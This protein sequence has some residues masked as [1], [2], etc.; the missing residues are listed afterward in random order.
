MRRRRLVVLLV[1]VTGASV[2]GCTDDDDPGPVEPTSGPTT[3]VNLRFGVWGTEP[4]IQAYQDVI[5]AYNA[6][7]DEA[8]VRIKPYANHD[9]LAAALDGGEVPDVF[10]VSR[11]DLAELR[12]KKLNRPIGDLL[13]ERN[14]DF[15]DGYSRP[16]LE[17]FASD[18]DLQC[19]PYGIS[20]MVIYYNKELVDFTAMAERELDVP[21]IDDEDLAKKPT[22]S[23]EQFQIAAEYASRPRREIAGF[24][25]AP[26]LR[27]TVALHLLRRRPAVR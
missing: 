17:A 11:G 15:G 4:E 8:A 19:M 10:L 22:W 26:T 20:P 6:E 21:N 24:Y 1:L 25:V 27:G 7:T 3:K 16:A 5:D 2:A 18:R 13:D 23:I 14:V 9:E 12:E